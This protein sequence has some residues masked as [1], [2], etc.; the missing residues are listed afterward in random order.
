MCD[1][2]PTLN[3]LESE[4]A[5]IFASFED[6]NP[7]AIA[8]GKMLLELAPCWQREVAEESV[9]GYIVV[10]GLEADCWLVLEGRRVSVLMS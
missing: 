10:V 2:L 6:M 9:L 7:C 5:F 4:C 8:W 1:A 3:P